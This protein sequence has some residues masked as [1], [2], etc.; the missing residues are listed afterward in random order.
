[1]KKISASVV[2]GDVRGEQTYLVIS[3]VHWDSKHCVRSLLKEHL[4][5]AVE[6]DAPIFIIGDFFDA[7]QGH[8]DPRS[9]KGDL[10]H[11]LDHPA[12]FDKMVEKAAEWLEPYR[13]HIALVTPGNHELSV[14]KHYGVGL[15]E[16][17]AGTLNQAGGTC[18]TGGY[19]GWVLF[20]CYNGD[21]HRGTVKMYYNHGSG[22]SSPVT[23]GTTKASR[24]AA[25]L[26][27]ADIVAAGHIHEAWQ[28][29]FPR[30]RISNRGVL[31]E[32]CQL[33]IQMA[34]YLADR[35]KDGNSWP[36]T[37]E[38]SPKPLG[39]WWLKFGI[40]GNEPTY[41]AVRAK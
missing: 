21:S 39:G 15:T 26:P 35:G 36:A 28:V 25:Y 3:D 34:A 6:R 16:R 13:G 5:E 40:R 2:E 22:G 1:M 19:E 33:H 17:L 29:E 23:K 38:F 14:T 10:L 20:R 41:Q 24:R 30:L 7:M 31:S 18:H 4:D 37:R 8:N 27:D 12:Y 11:E 32:D 9:M